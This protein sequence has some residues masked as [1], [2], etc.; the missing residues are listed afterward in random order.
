[1]TIV[2]IGII[3]VMFAIAASLYQLTSQDSA[4]HEVITQEY[5]WMAWP[6]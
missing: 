1:M 3:L 6:M 2:I 4:A 5:W